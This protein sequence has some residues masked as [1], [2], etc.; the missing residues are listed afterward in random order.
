MI[1]RYTLILATLILSSC[2]LSDLVTDPVDTTDTGSDII[3]TGAIGTGN[4]DYQDPLVEDI[5]G[6]GGAYYPIFDGLETRVIPV[7]HVT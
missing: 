3:Q 6:S 1:L 4:V 2:T 7:K 5:S